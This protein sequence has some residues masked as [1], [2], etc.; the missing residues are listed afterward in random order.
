MNSRAYGQLGLGQGSLYGA[1]A[2]P[3]AGALSGLPS[4]REGKSLMQQLFEKRKALYSKA[5]YGSFALHPGKD[6]VN[7]NNSLFAIAGRKLSGEE[8]ER[9]MENRAAQQKIGA[10]LNQENKMER[11]E[12]EAAEREL[13]EVGQS[14]ALFSYGFLMKMA[15]A[16]ISEAVALASLAEAMDFACPKLNA[17]IKKASAEEL[18]MY[19]EKASSLW[20]PA[21]RSRLSYELM[22]AAEA[23]TSARSL[24]KQA[25]IF[26]MVEDKK[27]GALEWIKQK[28]YGGYEAAKDL[29]GKGVGLAGS[30]LSSGYSFLKDKSMKFYNWLKGL[31]SKLKNWVVGEKKPEKFSD[32]ELEEGD[33]GDLLL[34][35][36]G[37]EKIKG[38]EIKPEEK[39]GSFVEENFSYKNPRE[40]ARAA[41][42]ALEAQLSKR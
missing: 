42:A 34:R 13:I 16:G 25:S 26:G 8:S 38:K 6:Y 19:V 7:I 30:A 17:A 41:L 3:A 4:S 18:D 35:G 9:A 36:T 29:L 5:P 22:Q 20:R 15:E 28:L 21:P 33:I 1:A 11:F 2:F 24:L 27:P 39:E 37:T 10:S 14:A 32:E 12:K 23:A 40:R 31:F